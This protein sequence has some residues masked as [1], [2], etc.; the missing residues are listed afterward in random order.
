[1]LS[2]LSRA[3]IRFMFS[4]INYTRVQANKRRRIGDRGF[5]LHFGD[6]D[7]FPSSCAQL[8]LMA[9]DASATSRDSAL[10]DIAC[11][12]CIRSQ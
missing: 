8:L 5:P 3:N 12:T 4:F 10:F 7:N 2:R 1:M 11:C 6:A 9:H